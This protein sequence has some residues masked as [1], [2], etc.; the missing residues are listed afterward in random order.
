VIARTSAARFK[1][2]Q[3]D[4]RQIGRELGVQLLVQGSIRRFNRRIRI[5]AQLT[6]LENLTHTW[7]NSY[8]ADLWDVLEVQRKL[9]TQVANSLQVELI[10]KGHPAS[11]PK[12]EAYDLYLQGRHFWRR[13]TEEG[14]YKAIELF[15]ESIRRDPSFSLPHTGVA[16]AY[17][18]LALYGIAHPPEAY[19]KARSALN[20]ALHLNKSLP[21]AHSSLGFILLELDWNWLAAESEHRQAIELNPNYASG[22]HWYGL[23]LMQVGQFQK[24]RSE[25]DAA[26]TLDPL[27]VAIHSHVGRLS[28]LERDYDRAVVEFKRALELDPEYPQ[29]HYYLAM[30]HVQ[31]KSFTEALAEMNSA[32]EPTPGNLALL[33]GRAFVCRAGG[34]DA[35]CKEI[36]Q[37][38]NAY[39]ER[40]ASHFL[41]SFGFIGSG[42]ATEALECLER[43][44]AERS[45]WLLYLA[46]DPAFDPLRSNP[47][48][49]DLVSRVAL[50]QSRAATASA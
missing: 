32:L 50:E 12:T 28:Y 21:E 25:F 19:E 11:P 2:T 33:A 6:E 46:H 47:M 31:R 24:A 45:G 27:S 9:A 16:D 44:F 8:E 18:V 13:R 49:C 40:R 5:T 15:Q 10:P 34:K 20:R 22:H 3:T 39:R 23:N 43:A 41:A 29:A 37:F 14:C 7:A 42:R 1:G 48:F 30:T 17:I 38:Q 36:V 35:N 4:L 26:L